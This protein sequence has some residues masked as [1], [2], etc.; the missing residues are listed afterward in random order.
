[1]EEIKGKARNSFVYIYEGYVYNIDKRIRDT[2]RCAIR[3]TTGC[4]G[5][6]TVNNDGTV[7][8]NTLH[9]HPPNYTKIQK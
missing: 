7:T 4:R 6:A 3:R 8:V 1:M 5:L 9:D 2:Y